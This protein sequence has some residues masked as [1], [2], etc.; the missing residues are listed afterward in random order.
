MMYMI[1]GGEWVY[2]NLCKH[3]HELTSYNEVSTVQ[4]YLIQI[5]K[6][7]LQAKGTSTQLSLPMTQAYSHSKR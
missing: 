2:K 5:Q 7:H 3:S 6:H 4:H 1:S